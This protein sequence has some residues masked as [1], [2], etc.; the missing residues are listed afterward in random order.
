ML[1]ATDIDDVLVLREIMHSSA[2]QSVL[3][4]DGTWSQEQLIY[5]YVHFGSLNIYYDICCNLYFVL[6]LRLF[7]LFYNVTVYKIQ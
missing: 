3:L 7:V 4:L 5:V 6:S 2:F 1:K